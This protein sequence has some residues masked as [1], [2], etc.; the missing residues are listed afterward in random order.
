M[1][2][3]EV[4]TNFSFEA[5]KYKSLKE[6]D[7]VLI[8]HLISWEKKNL[9][10]IFN[11]ALQYSLK[12][13]SLVQNLYEVVGDSFFLKEALSRHYVNIPDKHPFK[14]YQIRDIDDFPFLEVVAESVQVFEE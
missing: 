10:V 3:K 4:K 7:R 5:A 11:T 2:T 12:S 9:K 6:E 13:R 8:V 1:N 14:F